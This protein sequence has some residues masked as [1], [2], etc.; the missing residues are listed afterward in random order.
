MSIKEIIRSKLPPSFLRFQDDWRGRYALSREQKLPFSS[1]SLR[2]FA[3]IDINNIWQDNNIHQ[4]WNEDHRIIGDIFGLGEYNLAVSPDCRQ[5]IYFLT[6]GLR[7]KRVLEIG[8]NVGGSALYIAAALKRLESGGK[9]VTVDIVDVN[10]PASAPWVD[11]GMK[12]S[13]SKYAKELNLDNISFHKSDSIEFLSK[14]DEKF[15]LI[16]LDGDHSPK[17]VYRET[18]LALKRLSEGGI[19][20]LHDYYDGLRQFNPNGEYIIPGPFVACKRIHSENPEIEARPIGISP[21]G[22]NQCN[23]TSLALL[24]RVGP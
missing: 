8:T 11:F 18:S 21:S 5:T 9:L 16:F 4:Y 13:P 14:C 15:D 20:L 2:R 6:M 24:G 1:I 12:N 17:T 10:H 7:P 23:V 19:I 22:K 3:T